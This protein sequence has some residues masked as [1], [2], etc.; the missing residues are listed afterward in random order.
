MVEY[1]R[2]K[3][4]KR[5]S[6][7]IEV[8]VMRMTTEDFNIY[9][10][11]FETTS[12]K[13]YEVEGSVRVYLWGLMD[14]EGNVKNGTTIEEFLDNTL[15][16]LTGNNIIY[17][18]N[19]KFDSSFILYELLNEG[20]V[21]E[22]DKKL[23]KNPYSITYIGDGQ[24]TYAI[25]VVTPSGATIS[26]R[27]SLKLFPNM[28][29][30]TLGHAL[31]FEKL[32]ELIT[33]NR[34]HEL[35][36]EIDPLE[37]KYMNRDIDILR[38]TMLHH[39]EETNGVIYLT[40]ASYAED[41]LKE[42]VGKKVF[43]KK[44]PKFNYYDATLMR[45]AYFGGYVFANENYTDKVL[46]KGIVLDNNSMFPGVMRSARL[47][48]G[49]PIKFKGSYEA[50]KQFLQQNDYD[51]FIVKLRNLK[52]K[53]KKDHIPSLPKQLG[54]T[55]LI[56]T[57]NDLNDRNRNG[58]M[59]SNLD[60]KHFIYNYD[61]ESINYEFGYAFKSE[62][63]PFKNFVDFYGNEKKK[64]KYGPFESDEERELWV[65][66]S[67]TAIYDPM[68][69]YSAKLLLNSSYG[70]F[71]QKP[72]QDDYNVSIDENGKLNYEVVENSEGRVDTE[73]SWHYIPMAIFITATGRDILLTAA[74]KAPERVTYMDTDSLHLMGDELPDNFE[75]IMDDVE[76]GKWK[77]EN[78]FENAKYLRD[79]T[80]LEFEKVADSYEG[81][82]VVTYNGVKGR[83]IIKA[84]GLTPESKATIKTI[85]DFTLE[86]YYDHNRTARRVKGGTLIVEV[87]KKIKNTL[88]R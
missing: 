73:G 70:K 1:K 37:L 8:N 24:V 46:G 66:K 83:M 44:Y 34:R 2:S 59:L 78:T 53:V 47:P 82:D 39:F 3:T 14:E 65:E 55:T 35:N 80:Y 57:E 26:F 54:R 6:T 58:F 87:S 42:F 15:G 12:E 85:E 88:I 67:G 31:G 64:A 13:D 72:F 36:E 79:K 33:Y 11:D 32:S 49:E 28:S 51:L 30:A 38:L 56:K 52:F 76:L 75:D 60:L 23:K 18:H 9:Y 10:A 45:S 4:F 21:V 7:T 43:K 27:D 40:R 84:A 41:S 86:R 50:N 63:G 77:I 68:G 48:Y 17:F 71:G 62:L 74:E 69:F 19:L 16:N 22:Q 61:I 5:G 81:D 25:N 20:Y 29:I